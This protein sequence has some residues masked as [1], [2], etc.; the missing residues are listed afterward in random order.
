MADAESLS[1]STERCTGSTPV[2]GT[3]KK[4]K[5]KYRRMADV[6][7]IFARHWIDELDFSE[8]ALHE[9]YQ[10]ESLG[11]PIITDNNG[12]EVGK[13]YLNLTVT[14]WKK[15]I[16]DGILFRHELYEEPLFPHW[17]LDKILE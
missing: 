11:I 13:K 17:W 6:Y 9:M 7:K 4:I 10:H 3:M 2:V 1:L 15:D 12:Y 16:Q 8:T 5:N 14:M